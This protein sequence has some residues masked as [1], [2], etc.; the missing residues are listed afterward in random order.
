MSLYNK[1]GFYLKNLK[2]VSLVGK[3]GQEKINHSIDFFRSKPPKV[4]ANKK[5]L[6][7]EDYFKLKKT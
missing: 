5:I 1:Y 2:S 3:A 6:F 4:I 7:I